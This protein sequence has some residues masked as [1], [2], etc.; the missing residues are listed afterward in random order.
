[1]K[2]SIGTELEV[3]TG[4]D[5]WQATVVDVNE[6]FARVHYKGGVSSLPV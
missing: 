6:K 3:L 5:W 4:R 1:M 2:V